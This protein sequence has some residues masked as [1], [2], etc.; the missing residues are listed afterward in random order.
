VTPG[1]GE[2]VDA[3]VADPTREEGPPVQ[4]PAPHPTTTHRP[5]IVSRAEHWAQAPGLL[6]SVWRYRWLVVLAAIVGVLGGF[7]AAQLQDPV[8]EA[9]ALMRLADPRTAGVF[10]SQGTAGAEVYMARRQDQVT[11]REVTERAAEMLGAGITA[12]DVRRSISVSSDSDLLTLTV[13]AQRGTGPAAA[14]MADTVAQA[15]QQVALERTHLEAEKE[16][17]E[18]R[19]AEA[20]LEDRI[21][22]VE[23]ELGE[24][25]ELRTAELRVDPNAPG[26][27]RAGLVAARLENLV[28][29]LIEVES[30]IREV[31]INAEVVG[32]GVEM[33][34]PATVP[35][36]PIEPRPRV[37]ASLGGLFAAGLAAAFAYWRGGQ[38]ARV[39]SSRDVER[40]LEAP[41][42]GRLPVVRRQRPERLPDDLVLDPAVTEAYQFLLNSIE[43]ELTRIGGSS[44]LLTSAGPTQGKTTACIHLALAAGKARERNIVLVDGDL[45]AQYLTQLLDG[46]GHPG[47]AELV[48]QEVGLGEGLLRRP[49]T[50][51]VSVW[52]VPAGERARDAS[53]LRS[54]AFQD[55]MWKIRHRADL[56]IVDSA[57]VL[58]VA[59]TTVLAAHVD[60][61]VLIVNERTPASELERVRER[62]SFVSAPL[63]GF[64][65]VSERSGEHERY[66]YY[67]TEPARGRIRDQLAGTTR[68]NT[69]S[70]KRP[71]SPSEPR[72][73][74]PGTPSQE[75]VRR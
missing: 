26:D 44:I 3:P 62:L 6:I 38:A 28:G 42:L 22:A 58:A 50:D 32:S 60:A 7:V 2:P 14:T 9:T 19:S 47:L 53:I 75:R 46:H 37:L 27:P 21:E 49:I 48:A 12:S 70:S 35:T 34:E 66:G 23:E 45:R 67:A 25:A 43:Y 55:L 69:P 72:P 65:Y 30:R 31:T 64:I 10:E 33:F 56:T 5:H 11:S 63:L 61:V 73:R 29:Q 36:S 54:P 13:R 74:A 16:I 71:D 52:A 41:L 59:D 39:W 68:V 17:S 15:Y 4:A 20:A 40:L 24:L 18:L 8:Y 57:P 51:E 1:R